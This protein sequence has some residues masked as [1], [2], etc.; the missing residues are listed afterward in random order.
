M[1]QSPSPTSLPF[2]RDRENPPFGEVSVEK[3]GRCRVRDLPELERAYLH[4]Q[5]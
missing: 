4:G 2:L 3:T 5:D 1:E